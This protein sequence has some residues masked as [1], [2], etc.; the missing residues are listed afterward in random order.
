MVGQGCWQDCGR[1]A[2]ARKVPQSTDKQGKAVLLSMDEPLA[3]PCPGHFALCLLQ[4]RQLS[5]IQ[6]HGPMGRDYPLLCQRITGTVRAATEPTSQN[7]GESTEMSRCD[8]QQFARMRQLPP[9]AAWP[10]CIEGWWTSAELPTG[11]QGQLW[12][13][14]EALSRPM[15]EELSCLESAVKEGQTEYIRECRVKI[16][17]NGHCNSAD[18]SQTGWTEGWPNFPKKKGLGILLFQTVACLCSSKRQRHQCCRWSVH[19]GHAGPG[20]WWSSINIYFVLLTFSNRLT[21]P[22]I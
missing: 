16:V 1:G 17:A 8:C 11:T 20:I 18:Q 6:K 10:S 21:Q 14:V 15:R 3:A 4:C 13:C 22:S 5:M 12:W 9:T 7:K 19:G 2:A